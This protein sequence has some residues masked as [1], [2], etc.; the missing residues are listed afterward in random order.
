M[1]S[2]PMQRP[3]DIDERLRLDRA[4]SQ[5]FAWWSPKIA[6]LVAAFVLALLN[7]WSMIG[8][9]SPTVTTPLPFPWVVL[10]FVVGPA[11]LV[12]PVGLFWLWGKPLFQGKATSRKR[13]RAAVLVIGCLSFMW[14]RVGWDYGLRYQNVRYNLMT[15][16]GSFMFAVVIALIL[17]SPRRTDRFAW[18]L[19]ANFLLFA[20]LLTYAFPYLGELP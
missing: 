1:K 16:I 17:T 11:E 4:D 20:W 14:F 7:V 18:S 13:T 15:A 10:V 19:T 3:E 5:V 8:S 2:V 12:L 6:T 9:G